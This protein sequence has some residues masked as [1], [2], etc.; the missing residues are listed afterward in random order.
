MESW[1]SFSPVGS[2]GVAERFGCFWIGEAGNAASAT[3]TEADDWTG[4]KR[5]FFLAAGCRDASASASSNRF[6][7]LFHLPYSRGC[8]ARTW[9]TNPVPRV[10]IVAQN[11]HCSFCGLSL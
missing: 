3:S 7:F 11:G 5:R 4:C 9:A 8:L 2:T 6:G 10:E 1:T